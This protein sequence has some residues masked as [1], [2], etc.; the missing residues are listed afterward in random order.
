MRTPQTSQFS[1]PK[2]VVCLIALLV[3]PLARPG[4]IEPTSLGMIVLAFTIQ[5][6]TKLLRPNHFSVVDSSMGLADV[7]WEDRLLSIQASI[8]HPRLRNQD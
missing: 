8:L 3:A 7:R 2:L 5:S 1:S 6:S 4:L